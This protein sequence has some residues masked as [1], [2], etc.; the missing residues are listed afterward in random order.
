VEF[1]TITFL[2]ILS[3]SIHITPPNIIIDVKIIFLIKVPIGIS[4]QRPSK[5]VVEKQP[6]QVLKYHI[7]TPYWLL[8][9]NFHEI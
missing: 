6:A 2:P 1:I 9:K 5:A 3:S 7:M 4:D 8:I